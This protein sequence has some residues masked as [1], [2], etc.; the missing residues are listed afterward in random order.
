MQGFHLVLQIKPG[1]GVTR[2]RDY[3][4]RCTAMLQRYGHWC[5]CCGVPVGVWSTEGRLARAHDDGGVHV[6]Q[7]GHVR[8]ASKSGPAMIQNNMP[9]CG[10]CNTS[11]SPAA[12]G[13]QWAI[14]ENK[15]LG[16]GGT[17]RHCVRT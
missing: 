6:A 12:D 16:A 2:S 1:R 3:K 15:R 9:L 4:Q 7:I 5:Y 14:G 11:M 17:R 13:F 8:A 10:P